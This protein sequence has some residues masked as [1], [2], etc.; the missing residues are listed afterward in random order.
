VQVSS[1]AFGNLSR[2]QARALGYAAL[3]IC[4]VPHPFERRTR[5][6]VH[7]L[8]EQ[9]VGEIARLLCESESAGAD[10]GITARADLVEVAA[11][12]DAINRLF[13]ERHWTDG[14]PVVAPTAARVERMLAAWKGAPDDIVTVVPPGMG[15]ATAKR[16]A[17]N[18]VMAG[19]DPEYL[20]VVVAAVQAA[21]AREFNL[22]SVQTSTNPAG[23]WLIVNGPVARALGMNAG[24][25]CMGNGNW[26]NATLGRALRLALQNLG[27]ALPGEMDRATHGQPGKYTSCCAEIEDEHPWQPLHVE[28]G[29][30]VTQSTVTVVAA[31]SPV[32]INTHAKSADEL[33]KVFA[34]ALKRPAGNDYWI[35]GEPWLV[36]SPWHAN[37][38]K[39]GGLD[40]AELKRRLWE[41]SKI[42]GSLM[43]REDREH[44]QVG[45]QKELGSITPD[46]LLPISTR[47]EHIGIIIAGG[48]GTHT[49]YVP[50]FGN[51]RSVT[52]LIPD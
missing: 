36:M 43:S 34:L 35:G 45:R 9:C 32:N 48:A 18:A 30:D 49:L 27:R 13:R 42:P 39:A 21:T 19:C 26:A 11:D 29:Y 23:V 40:K 8:A 22:Q 28:R 1:A 3:P 38:F 24:I 51:T 15:E 14:L 50:S 44:T 10:A 7:G 41:E 6:E 25:N 2:V 47:P 33:L 52:R 16:I 31:E 5:T 37:V 20:P 12:E 17:I 46:T 4:V